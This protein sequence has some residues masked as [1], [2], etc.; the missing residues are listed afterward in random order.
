LELHWIFVSEYSMESLVIDVPTSA[1]Q[2][3]CSG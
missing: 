2:S 3:G 1:L